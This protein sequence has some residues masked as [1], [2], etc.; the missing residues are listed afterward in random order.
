MDLLYD[1][2]ASKSSAQGSHEIRPVYVNRQQS[3]HEQE[4]STSGGGVP[5]IT[6]DDGN[7]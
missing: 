7:T 6:P 4:L 1:V 2:N 5:G 3:F